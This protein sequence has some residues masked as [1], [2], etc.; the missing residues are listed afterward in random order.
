MTA[1]IVIITNYNIINWV[2][3]GMLLPSGPLRENLKSLKKY[4]GIFLNGNGE[5]I[6][7]IK[8]ILNNINPNLKIFEA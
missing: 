5:D 4:D 6:V 2:G 1:I 8:N 7:K 3:N